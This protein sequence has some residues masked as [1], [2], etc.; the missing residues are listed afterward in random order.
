MVEVN[1]TSHDV[2]FQYSSPYITAVVGDEKLEAVFLELL[3]KRDTYFPSTPIGVISEVATSNASF[4]LGDVMSKQFKAHKKVSRKRSLQA[5]A[6]I[7]DFLSADEIAN[8]SMK[9]LSELQRA[10]AWVARSIALRPDTVISWNFLSGMSLGVRATIQRNIVDIK[11]E[12]GIGFLLFER[13]VAVIE[14]IADKVF[15]FHPVNTPTERPQIPLTGLIQ[16]VTKS[17]P[18]EI[19]GLDFVSS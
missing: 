5:I 11:S 14:N 3:L 6:E 17:S 4:T 19:S 1:Y 10:H 9:D 16:G 7:L 12:L 2:S 18:D 15:N 8:V 13:R